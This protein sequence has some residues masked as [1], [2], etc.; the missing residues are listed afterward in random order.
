M[1]QLILK[2][3]KT[4]PLVWID[5]AVGTGIVAGSS[6]PENAADFYGKVIDWLDKQLPLVT[7]PMHWEFRLT[8]FNTSSTKG[9]Y[10]LLLRIKAHREQGH[11]HTIGW[12][13]EDGDE[14]MREAGEN[15]VELLDLPMVFR[16]I[17]EETAVMEDQKFAIALERRLT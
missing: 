12:D 4:T 11:L 6:M 15:F 14:F 9:L 8:Y 10:Q 5:T 7:K 16:E 13:V 3:T 17:S 2:A 1:E